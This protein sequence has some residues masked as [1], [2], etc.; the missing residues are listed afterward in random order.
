[1]APS[2]LCFEVVF[3]LFCSFVLFLFISCGGGGWGVVAR[4]RGSPVV[5][6]SKRIFQGPIK[7]LFSIVLHRGNELGP[8][9]PQKLSEMT[10]IYSHVFSSISLK[11]FPPPKQQEL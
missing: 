6:S 1:M 11:H 4:Q 2:V 10:K 7:E 3:F 5:H 8:R 9:P